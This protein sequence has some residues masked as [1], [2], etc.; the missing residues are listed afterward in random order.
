MRKELEDKIF[1]NYPDLFKPRE[2]ELGKGKSLYPITLGIA[3]RDGWYVIIDELCSNID[4][5]VKNHNKQLKVEVTQIKEK[6]G[7][8]NF[9]VK[10]PSKIDDVIWGM[11]RF[12]TGMSSRT[13]E[14]C[15]STKNVGRTDSWISTICFECYSIADER[16]RSR[17]WKLLY[18]INK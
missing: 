9:N 14:F 13:C 18:K 7:T 8:L 10:N 5:Y 4:F 15:G 6:F 17:N 3:C 2:P 16:M 12:A 11:I 1:N